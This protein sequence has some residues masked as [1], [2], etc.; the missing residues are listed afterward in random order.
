MW[1]CVWKTDVFWIV[2]D[3]QKQ[4]R[5][6]THLT[7]NKRKS[8]QK[9]SLFKDFKGYVQDIENEKS[10]G[11]RDERNDDGDER[12]EEKEFVDYRGSVSRDARRGRTRTVDLC[13]CTVR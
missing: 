9:S 13:E 4:N 6:L 7:K 11:K 10:S 1:E 2:Y 3:S 12:D 8:A 5:F